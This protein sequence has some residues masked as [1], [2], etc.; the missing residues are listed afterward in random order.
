MR[1]FMKN[2]RIFK[3]LLTT[4]LIIAMIVQ[5]INLPVYKVQANE[6]KKTYV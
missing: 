3:K 1:S 5:V 6:N 4:T 2:R